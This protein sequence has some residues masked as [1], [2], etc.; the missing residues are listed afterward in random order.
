MPMSN[1]YLESTTNT[2]F[3]YRNNTIGGYDVDGDGVADL[4]ANTASKSQVSA[5][6][7][8]TFIAAAV[9]AR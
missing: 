6:A 2:T 7:F 5:L 9:L 1:L 4:A 8:F 3:P